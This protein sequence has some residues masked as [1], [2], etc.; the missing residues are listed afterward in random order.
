MDAIERFRAWARAAIGNDEMMRSAR[1]VAVWAVFVAGLALVSMAPATLARSMDE[2]IARLTSVEREQF[3][4][5]IAAQ[6]HHDH[7]LDTYWKDVS[8]RR[9]ERKRKRISGQ[10][11]GPA[12]YVQSFPPTYQGPKLSPDLAKRWAQFQEQDAAQKPPPKPKPGLSD[13][14]AHAKAQYDF[15]PERISEREFKLRYAREALAAGLS[16]DQVV[17]IYA[18]ETSG[19]GTADMVAGIHP[20]KKTGTPISSAIGYAQ[21]L[22][23]NTVS[24][25]VKSGPKF[26]ER[27]QALAAHEPARAPAIRAKIAS[28]QK[29]INVARSVPDEWSRHMALAATP[30][31]LGMHAINIDGDIGPWLQVVKLKGLKTTA[32]RKGVTRL[33]GA[34]IELMNLAGPLTGLEMMQPA[35]RDAPTPN[36]FERNA[37]A[38]NTI[39][40]GKTASQLIVALDE[41]MD[42]NVK[43]SGAVE[44]AAVF[45]ELQG[46]AVPAPVPARSARD[47]AYIPPKPF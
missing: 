19:L 39:V 13:F 18:L 33:S 36:F 23:A 46:I 38:R 31:G 21:L 5:Y 32:T 11:L 35:A 45:D 40:R 17:R 44:F 42:Q 24:E 8:T 25:L 27:L 2:F 47:D 14:L 6:R 12:D 3:E 20:I 34:E 29:M 4:A 43:N 9:A 37:Y 28:L 1:A 22:A 7:Q 30:R 41:R 16:K 15:V 10:A 26:V